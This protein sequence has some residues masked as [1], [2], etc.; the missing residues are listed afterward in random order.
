MLSQVIKQLYAD[1]HRDGEKCND[2]SGGESVRQRQKAWPPSAKF[3]PT[4]Q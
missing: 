3:E 1:H 2:D 4:P